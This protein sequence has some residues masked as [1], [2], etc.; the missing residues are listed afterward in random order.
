M[1]VAYKQVGIAPRIK[2]SRKLLKSSSEDVLT[3]ALS[4]RKERSTEEEKK[5]LEREFC[6]DDNGDEDIEILFSIGQ[7]YL[8]QYLERNVENSSKE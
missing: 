7:P 2:F 8:Y 6:G 3:Q 5:D 4:L 1:E